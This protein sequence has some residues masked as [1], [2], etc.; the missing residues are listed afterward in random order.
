MT[1]HNL[2]VNHWAASGTK[3]VCEAPTLKR[4][5][6]LRSSIPEKPL[7]KPGIRSTRQVATALS[8]LFM[9]ATSGA[10]AQQAGGPPPAPVVVETAMSQRLAPVSW[11]PATVIS[12]NKARLAAEVAGRL[13]AV[14]EVG[15]NLARGDVAA[16]LDD[17]LLQQTLNENLAAVSREQARLKFLSADVRRLEKLAKQNTATQSQLDEAIANL[18]VTRSELAATQARVG[19]TRERIERTV[20]YA[21]FDGVVVERLLEPGDWAEEG[22]AVLRLVDSA[23]LYVQAEGQS[24]GNRWNG[25]YHRAGG[26]RAIAALRVANHGERRR[27][28]RRSG[29]ARGHSRGRTPRSGRHR[30]RRAGAPAGRRGGIPRGG[31]RDGRAGRGGNGDRFRPAH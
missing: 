9:L 10:L 6:G 21:P 28:F 24:Q 23:S 1:E 15:T 12:R 2:H 11:Y 22:S 18:G 30:S 20:L 3:P 17:T 16:R 26:R 4:R 13:I 31:G 27:L 5:P 7:K 29:F 8:L 19:L 14:A 25:A